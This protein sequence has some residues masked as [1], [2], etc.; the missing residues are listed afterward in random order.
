M[1][2]KNKSKLVSDR[3]LA[4]VGNEFYYLLN[5]APIISVERLGGGKPF[6]TAFYWIN[7]NVLDVIVNVPIKRLQNT[8]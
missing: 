6:G 5:W 8:K 7:Y 3:F 1:E 2:T 4:G